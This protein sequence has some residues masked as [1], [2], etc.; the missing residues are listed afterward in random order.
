[1]NSLQ[2]TSI[3]VDL[4]ATLSTLHYAMILNQQEDTK[5]RLERLRYAESVIEHAKKTI[6]ELKKCQDQKQ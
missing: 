5:E 4:I 3:E 2:I 1:M 6:K